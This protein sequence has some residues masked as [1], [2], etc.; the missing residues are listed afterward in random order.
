MRLRQSAAIAESLG[1]AG[2]K[3]LLEDAEDPLG[4]LAVLRHPS[5]A[6][7]ERPEVPPV[8]R[9]VPAVP[10]AA[11][12]EPLSVAAPFTREPGWWDRQW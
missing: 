2:A 7:P 12:P 11:D 10:I 9:V 5:V 1:L 3:D 8:V 4:R 6:A